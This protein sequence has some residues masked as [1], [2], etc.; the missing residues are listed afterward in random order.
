MVV[1][2]KT[3][4][5]FAK[6]LYA[7][8]KTDRDNVIGVAGF[9]GEGKSAFTTQL[10]KEYCKVAN[11]YWGF[12]RMTWSRAEMM[13]WIDGDGPD[14]KGQLPEYSLIIPDELFQMF[15][16]RNWYENDQIDAIATFNMCRDRHLLTIGNIPNFWELD[17]GFTNR[18]RF[19]VYIPQRGVAWVFQQENNPFSNDPWNTGENKK[20]FRKNLNPFNCHNFLCQIN[21]DDWTPEEKEEYYNI[22]NT[23]RVEAVNEVKT[24]RNHKNHLLRKQRDSAICWINNDLFYYDDVKKVYS[25]PSFKMIG[26]NL[27]LSDVYIGEILRSHEEPS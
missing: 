10:G 3:I 27:H 5:D 20:I 24:V 13:R 26:E 1:I 12:D 8:L 17:A 7:L 16:R 19:Y 6:E 21:Y 23:K 22:R 11:T 9:T 15:Y 4:H 25:R 2:Y 18:I 14:K